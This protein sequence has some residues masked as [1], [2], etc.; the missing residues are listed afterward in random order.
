MALGEDALG[1]G[2]E[3]IAGFDEI[4]ETR[5]Q[6]EAVVACAL[7]HEADVVGALRSGLDAVLGWV[8]DCLGEDRPDESRLVVV[9]RGAV[10][11]DERD[12][13]DVALAPIW[14]LVRSAEQENPG[15]FVLVD[16]D[17]TGVSAETLAAILASAEPE[18]AVRN[19]R[20]WGRRLVRAAPLEGAD[21]ITET[22][23]S[24][25]SV[26]ITGGT[27]TLGGLVARHLVE[28]HGVEDL[29]LMSRSGPSAAGAEALVA[30]LEALG[31][32]VEVVACD[33]A[34]RDALAEVLEGRTLKAVV[35]T[36]GALDDG[37]VV[38]LTPERLDTVLAAK[39]RGAWNLHELTKDTALNAFVVFSSAAG[40]LGGVG[41]A[42]YA[43]ANTFLDALAHH[44]RANGLAGLSLAWGLWGET[45]GLT[46][47]LSDVDLARMRRSGL[48]PLGTEEAL[49][50]FDAA[51]SAD[52]PVLVAMHLDVPVLRNAARGAALSPLW[53]RLVGT[54]TRTQVATGADVSELAQRLAGLGERE[55]ERALLEVVQS[56][57]AIVLGYGEAAAVD[58]DRAFKDLGFDS[59]TAVELRNRLRARTGLQLPA[60]LVFD[61]PTPLAAARELLARLGGE[62]T[63]STALV[64]ATVAEWG[65]PLAIVGVG[66]RFPGGVASP[67]GLWDLV[68]GHVDAVGEFPVDRGWQ[69]DDADFTRRG[70]FLYDAAGF[71]A[72]FFGVSPREALAMDPQQRLLLEVS[73]EALE[74]A[75]IDPTSL[76]GSSTGVFAGLM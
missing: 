72:G 4:V 47:H 12:A 33:V 65:E 18:V 16:V 7:E 68:A 34:D 14:G 37:V 57:V 63:G 8:Q 23:W 10:R 45:S 73:W 40:V 48:A 53:E 71:D 61:H 21:V 69:V 11:L 58:G 44:R 20:V 25:G 49:G 28:T 60:T 13:I 56:E 38:G 2:L 1:L 42:N 27:G 50:L 46:G 3:T 35:H 19:G 70:G 5:R 32:Q 9:T 6:P 62:R 24:Q 74:R 64:R 75:G 66:C 17:S 76:R 55:R 54:V 39:A 59:L 22:D 67:E 43:A 26:L 51:L 15:R 36:A 29:V 30:D 31:A 52:K 41:Q